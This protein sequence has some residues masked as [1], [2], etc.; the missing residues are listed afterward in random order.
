M[1]PQPDYM[2][3]WHKIWKSLSIVRRASEKTA[4]RHAI[5]I[6]DPRIRYDFYMQT[7]I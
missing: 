3:F 4:S 1:C 5:C 7:Q 2:M 6:A